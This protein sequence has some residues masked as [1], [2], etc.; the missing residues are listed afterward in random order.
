MTDSEFA[1]T[2]R[3]ASEIAGYLGISFYRMRQVLQMMRFDG[4]DCTKYRRFPKSVVLKIINYYR[5]L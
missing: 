4:V 5:A 1:N 3:Y 2:E